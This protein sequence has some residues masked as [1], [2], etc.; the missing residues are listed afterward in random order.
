MN[1]ATQ[2]WINIVS[3]NGL[4]PSGNN[5]LPEPIVIYQPGPVTFIWV[6]LKIGR[7]LWL[8]DVNSLWPTTPYGRRQRSGS[9][10][11]QVMACCLTAASHTWTNVDWSSVKSS[12]I[13]IRAISQEMPQP[14]ITK[15]CLEITYLKFHSIFPGA[16]GA[17]ELML[18]PV[19]S[20]KIPCFIALWH[21]TTVGSRL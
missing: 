13:H 11:S 8:C 21:Y 2:N 18:L 12:V 4:V 20:S 17:N 6:H 5:P 7:T 19:L 3:G 16:T 9:T 14:L 15:I 1:T 10:L